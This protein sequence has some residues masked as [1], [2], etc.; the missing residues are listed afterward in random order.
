MASIA[1]Y[2]ANVLYPGSLRDLLIRLGQSG[3][4][5]AKWTDQILDEVFSAI[6]RDQPELEGK[7]ARTRNLMNEAI[8]DVRVQGYEQRI[9][10]LQL[11]DPD[12]RHVLAAAIE[13]RAQVIVTANVRDF[14]SDTLALFGTEAQPPDEFVLSM[15]YLDPTRVGDIIRDQARALRRPPMTVEELLDRL[16]DV[17]LRKSVVAMRQQL[18]M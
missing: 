13:S 8:A 10:K 2:D 16:H 18:G 6:V 4:I 9:A 3:L 5:Q 1:L 12:D 17:G 11:P 14:P 7:L 15:F